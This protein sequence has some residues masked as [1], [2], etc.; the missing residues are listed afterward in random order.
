MLYIPYTR[1]IYVFLYVYIYVLRY[2]SFYYIFSVYSVYL[3]S[4]L[5]NISYLAVNESGKRSSKR[6]LSVYLFYF[7]R[8]R[9]SVYRVYKSSSSFTSVFRLNPRCMPYN[10]AA[11]LVVLIR[12]QLG[13]LSIILD[14]FL[15]RYLNSL[16]VIPLPICSEIN[17]A[18]HTLARS[19]G[20]SAC[21]GSGA[22][23]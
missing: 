8:F 13:R 16:S 3:Y 5:L 17:S 11:C 14:T 4:Y 7:A 10:L 18:A 21:S 23:R 6:K 12:S 15:H 9:G 1:V 20:P 22:R 2:I 19:S